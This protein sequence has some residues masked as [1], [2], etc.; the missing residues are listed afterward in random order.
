MASYVSYKFLVRTAELE[1]LLDQK[2]IVEWIKNL[3]VGIRNLI[4]PSGLIFL[5]S[6]FIALG[7]FKN[8]INKAFC[9]AGIFSLAVFD[10]F[11]F[12]WK[13]TPFTSKDLIFPSTPVIDYLKKQSGIF[14]VDG[15]DAIPMNMLMPYRLESLSAYDAVYPLRMAQFM[16]AVNSGKIANPQ[17]R[18][19]DIKNY[20]NPL[21]DISNVCYVLAVKK[22]KIDRADVNGEIG[23]QFR[24]KKFEKV[25][26]DKTVQ[27][28]KNKNCAP[29]A[30]VV[31]NYSIINNDQEIIDKLLSQDFD[32]LKEIVLEKEPPDFIRATDSRLVSQVAAE[33]NWKKYDSDNQIL[34]VN[35]PKPSLLFISD[36]FYP[37]W[38][39]YVDDTK[40]EIYR[41]NFTFRAVAVPAGKHQVEFVYNPKSFKLGLII[42]AISLLVLGVLWGIYLI[43]YAKS[44]KNC[45]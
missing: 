44:K 29:R 11:R 31:N 12:G 18:H 13:Y 3:K 34:E 2:V 25:F 16:A 38:Q 27:V 21:F 15:G 9:V 36:T 14:R 28:L 41:A 39:A 1:G 17:T 37:G 20:N 40:S 4:L 23:W 7:H 45:C 26:E 19:G 32:F 6:F 22:D 24:L 30:F 10:I 35:V 42:S 43:E 5:S 8:K 33:V